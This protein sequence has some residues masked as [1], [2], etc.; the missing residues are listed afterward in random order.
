MKE[1]KIIIKELETI[2]KLKKEHKKEKVLSAIEDYLTSIKD[3]EFISKEEEQELLIKVSNGDKE[4]K[5]KLYLGN[6]YLG[7]LFAKENLKEDDDLMELIK[8]SN[9]GIEFAID[10][11]DINSNIKFHTY[12]I[13]SM[14]NEISKINS[15]DK[16][17]KESLEEFEKE[18]KDGSIKI[19][20]NYLN[21]LNTRDREMLIKKYG[22]NSKK[23]LTIEELT[24]EYNVSSSYI[25]EIECKLIQSIKYDLTLN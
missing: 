13:Y 6:L 23:K 20:L 8:A 12:I 14:R 17:K 24:K 15:S 9:K 7:Y 16:N 1:N 22:L 10:N 3:Y 11:Y 21:R 19:I 5:E 2:K 18:S 4:A 25:K